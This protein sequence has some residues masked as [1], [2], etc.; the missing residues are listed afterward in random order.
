MLILQIRQNS[1]WAFM[2]CSQVENQ[3]S[4]WWKRIFENPIA[5][6]AHGHVRHDAHIAFTHDL[7]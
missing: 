7:Q 1:Y 2:E 4:K 6:A 5:R 3:K